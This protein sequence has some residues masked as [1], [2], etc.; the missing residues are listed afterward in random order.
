MSRFANFIKLTAIGGLTES[1]GYTRT[2]LLLVHA[3]FHQPA[4]FFF[5][6][7]SCFPSARIAA[8]R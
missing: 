4:N 6:T 1:N 7:H 2:W 8:N 3:R 5:V